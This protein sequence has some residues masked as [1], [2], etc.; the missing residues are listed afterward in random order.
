[1]SAALWVLPGKETVRRV[2]QLGSSACWREERERERRG[3]ILKG[4]FLLILVPPRRKGGLNNGGCVLR[5]NPELIVGVGGNGPKAF[6]TATFHKHQATRREHG[7][8]S[9]SVPTIIL[10][11]DSNSKRQA[12]AEWRLI[13]RRLASAIHEY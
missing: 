1:M 8:G 4:F 7:N 3:S 10:A 12:T 13:I 9:Y 6:H 2:V 11:S 5:Q